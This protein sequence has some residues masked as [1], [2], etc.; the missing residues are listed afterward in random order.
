MERKGK[1]NAWKYRV[2]IAENI[3]YALL[4]GFGFLIYKSPSMS[5]TLFTE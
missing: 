2:K 5:K 4:M 3:Y 1:L